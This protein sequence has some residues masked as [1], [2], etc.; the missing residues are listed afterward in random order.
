[1]LQVTPNVTKKGVVIGYDARHNST[2]YVVILLIITES[3]KNVLRHCVQ[4]Q[5]TYFY[6]SVVNLN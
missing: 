5:L 2:R 3:V 4:F 6:K 1:M